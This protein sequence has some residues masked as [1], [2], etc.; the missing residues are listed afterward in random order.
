MPLVVPIDELEPGMRMANSLVHR[1]RVMMA[2]GKV[3]NAADL[4]ILRV[5]YPR[6]MVQVEDPILDEVVD[7][8]SD[9]HERDIARRAQ[10][11]IAEAMSS[12]GR[13]LS[14]RSALSGKDFA[15][16]QAAAMEVM[17]FLGDHPVTAALLHK[18][19]DEQSYLSDHAAAVFY[20]SMLLGSSVKGYVVRERAEH[21]RARSVHASTTFDMTPLGLGAL[22]MDLGMFSLT[23][24]LENPNGM[25]EEADRQA[26]RDHP[27]TGA[28]MLP[29]EFP[30]AA[31]SIVRTHHENMAGRGY[32]D[33]M[34]PNKL[35]VF[36]RIIRIC[37]AYHAATSNHVFAAART[38]SRA[39]WEM[40][41]G[42]AASFFDPLLVKMFVGLIQPF[43]IGAKLKL[44]DGRFAVLVKY[45]RKDPFSPTVVIAF[46]KEGKRLPMRQLVGPVELGEPG[47][48]RVAGFG[49]EDLSYLY[50]AH[51][52]IA[53]IS[54]RGRHSQLFS[55]LYP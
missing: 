42:P 23:H 21:T 32:P 13:K 54:L 9:A 44:D 1:G 52:T 24:L 38:P 22:F 26:L 55:A 4:D 12:V 39:I 28:E 50:D 48:P 16:A 10:G 46:D 47:I 29:G 6:A 53:P 2:K 33:A 27:I 34:A 3:V 20:L 30:P 41:A 31:R 8:E 36:T 45:N 37:D 7:F 49:D 14:S 18:S 25:V 51:A 17:K 43:P 5:R 35:H 11:R 19:L 40:T 15:A